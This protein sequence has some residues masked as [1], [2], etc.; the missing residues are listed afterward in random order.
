MTTEY[1][2][3]IRPAPAVWD[4]ALGY[5][6][7]GLL[8]IL[9]G[10]SAVRGRDRGGLA[11]LVWSLA[12]LALVYV[13]FALQRRFL[14]GLGPP[15]SMLAAMGLN[16][17]LLSRLTAGRARLVAALTVSFSALGNLFLLAVLI[18]G[19][20]NRH[21]QP[22]LFARL[23]LSRDEIAAMQWLLTHAQDEVVLAAP[24]TGMLL[25]GRS[26]VRV[27]V[28]HPFETIDA[29]TKEAQAEAFFRG[30]MSTDEWQRLREKYRIRYVFVGPVERALGGGGDHL[31]GLAPAFRQ[32]KVTIYHFP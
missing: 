26:G 1:T 21:G 4:L 32:G 15:L 14:T 2:R 19:V 5:G 31:R 7:V 6:L 11:L 10:M 3:P 8:A 25:P 23:Y 17:W 29:G 18:L 16:R 27:F 20:L 13:P 24:R 28:G 12:T 30:E 22:G 9:G